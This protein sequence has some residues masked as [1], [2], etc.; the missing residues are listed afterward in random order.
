MNDID[1]VTGQRVDY[2]EHNDNSPP[3]YS[4]PSTLFKNALR[5]H[6]NPNCC[7]CGGNGYI[8]S[9]KR[10]AGGRCFQ[11]IPDDYWDTLL[12]VLKATGTDDKTGES[13]CEVRYVSS[14]AY[15]STGYIVTRIGLPPAG[16]IPIFATI[17]EAYSYAR[18][19]TKSTVANTAWHKPARPSPHNFSRVCRTA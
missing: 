2:K 13:V 7:R 1:K 16:N 9:F 6:A 4:A 15:S 18:L 8:G 11:C 19:C 3:S 17:D 5:F 14:N 10:I 12:G